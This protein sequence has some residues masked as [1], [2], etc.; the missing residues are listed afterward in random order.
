[1]K[2]RELLFTL[3]SKDF[4]WN[5]FK[6]PGPG[7]Q[8]KNKRDT[9]CR[10]IHPPSGAMGIGT[11]EREQG[12]NRRLAFE[13]CVTSPKFRSWHRL[14]CVRII[15]GK[16]GIRRIEERIDRELAD[17]EKILVEIKDEKGRWINEKVRGEE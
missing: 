3:S 13:R 5:F 14:E 10:C 15:A 17:P 9:A 12:R 7:G 16:N 2:R 1:M 8:N 4:L 6:A 11:E